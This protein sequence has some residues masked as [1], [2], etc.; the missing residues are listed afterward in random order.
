M[1]RRLWLSVPALFLLFAAFYLGLRPVSAG[2]TSGDPAPIV[3]QPDKCWN[4]A[5]DIQLTGKTL[6]SAC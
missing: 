2:K 1:S 3:T 4:P 6:L 5:A